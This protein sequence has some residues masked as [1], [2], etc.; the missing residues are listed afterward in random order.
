MKSEEGEVGKVKMMR[1]GSK[2][3]REKRKRKLNVLIKYLLF[4]KK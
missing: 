3:E 1:G 4:I 2:G